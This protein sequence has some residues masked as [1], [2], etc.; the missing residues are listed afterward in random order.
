MTVDSKTHTQR[1]SA[2]RLFL[3][4]LAGVAGLYMVV[5]I[6]HFAVPVQV[7]AVESPAF[8]ERC[9]QICESYGLV[10]SG[11]IDDDARDFLEATDQSKLAGTLD[12]LLDDSAHKPVVSM[13]HSLLGQSAP[14]FSLLNTDLRRVALK[15]LNGAGPVVVVF[16][17]GYFCSHCVAQL[18]ALNDDIAYFQKLGASVVA[19]S[20]DPPEETSKRYA[21]YG[22]FNFYVLSDPENAVA[23]AYGVYQPESESSPSELQHATFVIDRTGTVAW[24]YKGDIPFTDNQSL[25]KIIAGV[26]GPTPDEFGV[27]R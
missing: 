20:A 14:E 13:A 26:D 10:P 12:Q 9:R 5:L 3:S 24:A 25:L 16:Y 18:F 7:G 27:E 11:R 23:E 17:Y 4:F 22:E 15:D 8:L 21:K 1:S 2:T 19:I 6:Y